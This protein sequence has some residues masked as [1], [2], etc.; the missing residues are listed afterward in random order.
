MANSTEHQTGFGNEFATEA[1]SGA[2]PIGRNSPQRAPYGLYAEQIS[3]TAFTAPRGENRRSWCYRLRPSAEHAPFELL[4]D[5]GL[6]RSGPFT[7][8]VPSP[9][10]LRWDPLPV[11]EKPTDFIDGL[12]TFAGNG[13]PGVRLG[14]AIHLYFVNKPMIDRFFYNSDGEMLIVPQLGNLRFDTEFGRIEAAPGMIVVIPQGVKFRVEPLDGEARGYICENYGSH[15]R[16]PALGPIGSNALANPRDFEAPVARFEDI[17]GSFECV[18]KYE[19][20]LWSANIGHSPLDVVAWHG[21]LTPY[22]YDLSRFCPMGS[23]GFDHPDPSIYT[24]LTSP[25][26]LQGIANVDFVIFPPRWLV[27]ENTFRPPWY[28]RNVMSEYMGLIY[29]TYDAKEGG[30]VPGGGSLHSGMQAHGPDRTTYEMASTADLVPRKLSES[31]AFMFESR[32]NYRPTR[33]SM[34]TPALQHDYAD[35]WKGFE[36]AVLPA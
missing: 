11:P 13:D 2:L 23:V 16:L 15:F 14:S 31:I 30:F 22:R 21:N 20:R 6:L 36:K 9:N 10:R 5:Q 12:T 7:D 34:E 28:H 17:E 27:A 32:W 35:C 25:S 18:Q 29:G 19:G 3:G 24:V 4:D 1:V 26:E 8:M 33:F